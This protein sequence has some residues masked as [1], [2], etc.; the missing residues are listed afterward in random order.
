MTL[1]IKLDMID[2][3]NGTTYSAIDS[4]IIEYMGNSNTK[5][6]SCADDTSLPAGVTSINKADWDIGVTAIFDKYRNTFIQNTYT[7]AINI[8]E[9]IVSMYHSSEISEGDK[10]YT[11]ALAAVDAST[12]TEADDAAPALF[13]EATT[14]GITTK[15]LAVLVIARY[16]SFVAAAAVISGRRGQITDGINAFAIDTTDTTAFIESLDAMILYFYDNLD[17]HWN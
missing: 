11:Q 12:D 5:Y 2:T 16:E 8:R 3:D 1:F 15:A 17:V 6:G 10:K 14:R 7:K 13:V 9:T 4:H